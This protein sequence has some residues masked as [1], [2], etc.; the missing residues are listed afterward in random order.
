VQWCP[1]EDYATRNDRLTLFRAFGD[2]CRQWASQRERA[3]SA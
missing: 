1:T 3:L 2:A